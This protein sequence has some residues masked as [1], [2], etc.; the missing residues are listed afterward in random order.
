MEHI[1]EKAVE[2]SDKIDLC[3]CMPDSEYQPVFEPV[4]MDK[5]FFQ[6]SKDFGEG[7]KKGAYYGGIFT[8]FLNCGMDTLIAHQLVA[9]MISCD[10]NE[11]MGKIQIE[12]AKNSTAQSLKNDL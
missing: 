7:I 12:V 6:K 5:E 10:N 4:E 3:D 8:A 2:V 9:A 11:K 1:E